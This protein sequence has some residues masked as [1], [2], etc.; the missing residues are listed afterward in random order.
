MKPPSSAPKLAIIPLTAMLLFIAIRAY[1]LDVSG[2]PVPEADIQLLPPVCKLILIEMPGIHQGGGNTSTKYGYLLDRPEYQMAKNNHHL[3]HYCWSLINRM[4]Y[5]RAKSAGE[6]DFWFSRIMDDT[7]YVLQN[8]PRSWAYFHVILLE[9]GLMMML[10]RDYK[11]AVAKAEEVL[12]YKP[13]DEQAYALEFDAYIDMQNREK[14]IAVAQEGLKQNPR[15][16]ILLRRLQGLGITLVAPAAASG[17]PRQETGTKDTST[18]A[19]IGGAVEAPP[20]SA[21]SA[22]SVSNGG[23]GGAPI[24]QQP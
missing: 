12:K 4:R 20:A 8:S 24:N 6:R 19:A 2:K 3:H 21:D 10:Q 9:Q 16:Q 7:D 14:A 15:S 5:F 17:P 18:A 22:S 13:D 23:A 1:A 11:G